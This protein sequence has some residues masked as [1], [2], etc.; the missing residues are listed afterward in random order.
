MKGLLT[1]A[2]GVALIASAGAGGRLEAASAADF[3]GRDVYEAACSRCHGRDGSGGKAPTLIPF[4][5]NYSQALDIVRRG[6]ACGMPAFSESDLGDEELKQVV[7]YLKML[8]EHV[9]Q[10]E[11]LSHGSTQHV[12]TGHGRVR[13]SS[14]ALRSCN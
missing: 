4:G 9:N 13:W 10:E 3:P 14:A 5:W 7:D 6:S 1:A 11:R 2:F 12:Q 8:T